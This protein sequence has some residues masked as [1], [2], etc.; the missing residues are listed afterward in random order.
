MRIRIAVVVLVASASA[1]LAEDA[2]VCRPYAR[3]A[4]DNIIKEVWSRAYDYCM[5]LEVGGR[6]LPPDTWRGMLQTFSPSRPV[7]AVEEEGPPPGS[8]PATG[9][10][11]VGR[12]G[13]AS[14][15]PEWLAWCRSRYRSFDPADGTVT[16]RGA[17]GKREPCPG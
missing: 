3:L 17:R 1:G 6:P 7:E 11:S 2:E 8:V 10:V 14:G 16:R 9:P 13:Y 4:T 15:S 5:N 12:S